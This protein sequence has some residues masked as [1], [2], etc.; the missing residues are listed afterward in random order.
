MIKV[1]IKAQLFLASK[2]INLIDISLATYPSCELVLYSRC[3]VD[4][5]LKEVMIV[6][7]GGCTMIL[8]YFLLTLFCNVYCKNVETN[9]KVSYVDLLYCL[10]VKLYSVN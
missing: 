4:V 9:A 2:G 5:G 8:C 10:V 1:A 6:F 3:V 7:F